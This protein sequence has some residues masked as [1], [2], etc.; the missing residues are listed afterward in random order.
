MSK[1]RVTKFCKDKH[2]RIRPINEDDNTSKYILKKQLEEYSNRKIGAIPSKQLFYW[3]NDGKQQG[4]EGNL[5]N[6]GLVKDQ[7]KILLEKAK[8]RTENFHKTVDVKQQ[9]LLLL[10]CIDQG[11]YDLEKIKGYVEGQIIE[12]ELAIEKFEQMSEE[13]FMDVVSKLIYG[14]ASKEYYISQHMKYINA[15][16]KIFNRIEYFMKLRKENPKLYHYI[17]KKSFVGNIREA[18]EKL[19]KLY[20]FIVNCKLG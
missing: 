9:N 12:H 13:E 14:V 3:I 18:K 10:H 8:K 17:I 2:I 16:N 19:E 11:G 6:L 7:R 4:I 1:K 15:Y 5:Q 20:Q